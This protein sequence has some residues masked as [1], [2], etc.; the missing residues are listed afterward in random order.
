MTTNGSGGADTSS[1]GGEM[2]TIR[3][4]WATRRINAATQ[5]IPPMS[6]MSLNVFSGANQIEEFDGEPSLR[7][8]TVTR[9]ARISK[10]ALAVTQ[11]DASFSRGR[12]RS[13]NHTPGDNLDRAPRSLDPKLQTTPR[14]EGSGPIPELAAPAPTTTGAAPAVTGRDASTDSERSQL[15]SFIPHE[16]CLR[17]RNPIGRPKT[18]RSPAPGR[19]S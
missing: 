7:R 17:C 3:T 4:G 18:G 2:T 6:M 10:R 1:I 9:I 14:A 8:V 19:P 13:G 11:T 5:R 15:I 12:T 16:S